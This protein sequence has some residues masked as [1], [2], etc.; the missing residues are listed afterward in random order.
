ML[1][2]TL[3]VLA[4]AC[5]CAGDEAAGDE[6]AV[7]HGGELSSE[8]GQIAFMRASDFDPPDMKADIY[9]TNIDGTGE[10][11]LT[12]SPGLDGFPTWSPDGQRIA[13][14]SDRGGDGNWDLYVMDSNGTRQRRLTYTPEEDEA[15]PAWSPD[16]EKIAYAINPDG[17]STIWVMDTEGSDRRQLGSGLFPN[18][19]PDGERIAYTTYQGKAYL[20]VMN[21]DG[22]ERRILGATVIQRLLRLGGG[23]EPAWAPGGERIAFAAYDGRDNSEIYVILFPDVRE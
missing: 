11:R 1:A 2:V 14:V 3:V 13:F 15:V 16:G 5:G 12:D 4:F 7:D 6:A 18:W 20:A 23:D 22:S 17:A 8:E 9:I 19:S 10:R 21:A